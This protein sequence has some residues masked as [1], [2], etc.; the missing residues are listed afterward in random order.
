MRGFHNYH[1][2]LRS[3]SSCKVQHYQDQIVFRLFKYEEFYSGDVHLF[4]KIFKKKALWKNRLYK[5]N[6]TYLKCEILLDHVKPSPDSG[7]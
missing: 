5:T 3:Q 2:F 1:C 7:K 4:K 6:Y